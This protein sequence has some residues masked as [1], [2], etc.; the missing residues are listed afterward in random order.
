VLTA[1]ER[2]AK[3]RA[4]IR[5]EKAMEEQ[6]R[7]LEEQKRRKIRDR[8]L[9]RRQR[10]QKAKSF[11]KKVRTCAVVGAMAAMLMVIGYLL[12]VIM[13]PVPPAFV[14]T[15]TDGVDI[16][17]ADPELPTQLDS[18]LRPGYMKLVEG[19]AEIT[20][21]GCA[22]A[23]IQ[24]PVE[25]ELQNGSRAYLQSGKL[26]ATVS[27]EA[28]GFTVNTPSASIIDLG[29]EF[30]VYV[31]EDCS[32][33]IHVFEGKVSLLAGKIDGIV[34]KP[35]NKAEQIVG[36]GQARRIKTGSSKIEETPFE[37]NEFARHIPSPYELA[38]RKTDPIAYWNFDL[39]ESKCHNQIEGKIK[40]VKYSQDVLRINNGPKLSENKEN[41]ALTILHKSPPTMRLV[42]VPLYRHMSNGY[43]ILF[44]YRP[45][46]SSPH[47][48]ITQD[49]DTNQSTDFGRWFDL[50]N[51]GKL[52]FGSGT[53]M[54]NAEKYRIIDTSKP[55]PLDQWTFVVVTI[56]KEGQGWLY[57]NGQKESSN[58]GYEYQFDYEY[59]SDP[60]V[61]YADIV[62]GFFSVED[63]GPYRDIEPGKPLA[64]I[65]ELVVY[66]YALSED[67]IRQLYNYYQP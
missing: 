49:R 21:D 35:L 34:D 30:G 18:P 52:T 32:S 67:T 9:R 4:F 22:K 13:Q 10:A 14:A 33:D 1:E 43:T 53:G 66:D 57:I 65:D 47:S 51:N 62:F 29:T 59:Q 26:T 2:Q 37:K 23:I 8:E 15:L 44:W 12:Y 60:K 6:E 41:G 54:N 36:A 17:W 56:T 11:M 46:V 28:R 16:K 3:I 64:I 24:A 58:K 48:I 25:I 55:L 31:K 50:E 19:Y 20:F 61:K 42:D 45:L 7:R 40:P 5:E 27:L 38:I 39:N 63:I